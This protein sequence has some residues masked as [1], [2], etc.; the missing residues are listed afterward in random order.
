MRDSQEWFVVDKMWS[1][2]KPK[3]H[4]KLTAFCTELTTI[5]QEQVDGAE[6]FD[7][8]FDQYT[9]WVSA[10]TGG[11]D[12]ILAATCGDW[13]LQ[14]MLPS[15]L[16]TSGITECPAYLRRWANLKAVVAEHTGREVVR[17][18]PQGMGDLDQIMSYLGLQRTGTLHRG[19]E[20]AENLAAAVMKMGKKV[21]F[22][23]T[24]RLA[25]K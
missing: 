16:R 11:S 19:I 5:T 3:V 17:R 25:A 14:T 21:V 4:P 8:V 24:G 23:E 2:V 1:F 9:G 10:K 20:D 7:Q 12:R 22:K 6:E 15:Q 18:H 13:D